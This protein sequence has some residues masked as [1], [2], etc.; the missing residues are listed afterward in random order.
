MVDRT[1][2]VSIGFPVRLVAPMLSMIV[3]R[4]LET[5]ETGVLMRMMGVIQM[6]ACLPGEAT[7]FSYRVADAFAVVVV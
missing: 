6:L 3:R 2:A 1:V 4:I 7:V 5:L